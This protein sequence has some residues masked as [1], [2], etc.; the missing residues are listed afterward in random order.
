[1]AITTIKNS[2][3]NSGDTVNLQAYDLSTSIELFTTVQDV[4][5]QNSGTFTERLPD[6]HFSG[7]TGP[8]H[9]VSGVY[10]IQD[11]HQT[12]AAAPIDYTYVKE[13]ILNAD[14]TMTLVDDKLGSVTVRLMNYEDGRG[15]QDS[16]DGDFIDYTMV[17]K[18]VSA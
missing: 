8:E 9:T 17:F 5:M 7:Y 16:N 3:V 6:G 11:A 12:G 1:M 2:G 18:E 13:I 14:K 4:P 10:R 15:A